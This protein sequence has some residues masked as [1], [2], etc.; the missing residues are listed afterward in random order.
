MKS[1]IVSKF[2]V[3]TPLQI[4]Q[5]ALH[6]RLGPKFQNSLFA[7]SACNKPGYVVP[8]R[9]SLMDCNKIKHAGPTLNT[10]IKIH[11]AS[12]HVFVSY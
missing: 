2:S 12:L 4:Q 8:I 1:I 5:F 3:S 7:W 11:I 9:K 10:S 6:A